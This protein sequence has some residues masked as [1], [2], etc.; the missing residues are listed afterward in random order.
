MQAASPRVEAC[1]GVQVGGVEERRERVVPWYG[2]ISREAAAWTS[3]VRRTRTRSRGGSSLLALRSQKRTARCGLAQP[4]ATSTP[5]IGTRAARRRDRPRGTRPRAC[6]RPWVKWSITTRATAIPRTPSSA[7]RDPG[8]GRPWCRRRGLSSVDGEAAREG[9]SVH[10]R[11]ELQRRRR[12]M[13]DGTRRGEGVRHGGCDAAGRQGA[14]G[15][16]GPGAAFTSDPDHRRRYPSSAGRPRP[17]RA[18]RSGPG[19]DPFEQAVDCRG[20]RTGA[21]GGSPPPPHASRRRPGQ[22]RAQRTD[23]QR[24]AAGAGTGAPGGLRCRCRPWRVSGSGPRT[25][26]ANH[27]QGGVGSRD[28]DRPTG[29]T[30]SACCSSNCHRRSRRG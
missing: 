26:S 2:P 29:A 6:A 25:S 14:R 11:G 28:L 27:P 13:V 3:Q 22:Q 16:C 9:S 23:E 19:P 21:A 24:R 20:P 12:R 5:V 15:A 30:A 10:G 18:G 17:G 1:H 8:G 7:G 4:A